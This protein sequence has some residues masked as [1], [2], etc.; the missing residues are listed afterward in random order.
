MH[1]KLQHFAP[2][3]RRLMSKRQD[4]DTQSAGKP[5]YRANEHDTRTSKR[6]KVSNKG[7]TEQQ[8]Q[9]IIDVLE[10][11]CVEVGMDQIT[12]LI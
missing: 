11:R 7:H 4:V 10:K 1:Q 5:T 2:E 9:T 12:R 3:T 6:L 8:Q